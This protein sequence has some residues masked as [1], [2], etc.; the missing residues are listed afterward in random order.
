VTP[1][2]NERIVFYYRHHAVIQKWATIRNELPDH[3]HQSLLDL[4]PRFH[5]LAN[6]LQVYPCPVDL[7]TRNPKLLLAREGWTS[8]ERPY[9]AIGLEWREDRVN[10]IDQ[11]PYAGV[12]VDMRAEGGAD[13]CGLLVNAL[14]SVRREEGYRADGWWPAFASVPPDLGDQFWEDPSGYADKVV[15]EVRR[16]WWR[17]ADIV[18]DVLSRH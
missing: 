7:E 13:L 1:I 10:L 11:H 2:D 8:S 4:S 5:D 18:D 14:A 9:V 16:A 6:E 3:V 17:C 15:E 12:W